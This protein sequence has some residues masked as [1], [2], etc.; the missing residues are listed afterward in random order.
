MAVEIE[1]VG[2]EDAATLERRQ[3]LKRFQ[4]A[5]VLC[6]IFMVVE[7]VGGLIAGSLAV[8]SDAAHLSSDLA[9]FAVAI[10]AN[11]LASLPSSSKHTYGLR[12]TESLAALFSMVS[13]VMICAGLFVEAIRRLW[14]ILVEGSLEEVDGRLMS[15]IATIGVFVNLALAYVLGEDHGHLPGGGGCDSHDHSHGGH[16]HDEPLHGGGHSHDEHSH[17]CHSH[18]EHAHD[19]HSHD[20]HAHDAHAHDNHS[21]DNHS[22]DKHSHD[23][24]AH[25]NHAHDNHSHDNHAHDKHSH[26]PHALENGTAHSHSH[27]NG[28]SEKDSLLHSNEVPPP[29]CGDEET[30]RNVNLEAAYLH[31]LGD[32]AQSVAVLI[33]GLIIWWKPEY[34]IVDPL[35]TLA[36]CILVFYSTLGVLKAAIAVLLE[37]VPPKISWHAVHEEISALPSIRSCHDLH[38]WS[39]SHG[40]PCLSAHCA[41]VSDDK[42]TQALKDVDAVCRS[43]GITHI[44]IQMQPASE[45]ACLTCDDSL[46]HP[47]K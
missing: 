42:C 14:Q 26:D 32:L 39:I 41:A 6:L 47:C 15:G 21:H 31:V 34:A 13:L 12:R 23:N 2:R 27:N 11:Y 28:L 37:E 3:V 44:T 38:I 20:E 10:A 30:K 40:I 24:H 18:D 43:H 1:V 5:T 25:D 17:D 16:S 29:P 46:S 9:S 36:F 7:I 4:T 19:N 35:I 33:A 45:T 8:L 22:H